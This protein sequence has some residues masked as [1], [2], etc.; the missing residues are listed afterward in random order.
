MSRE[1][2]EHGM[3]RLLETV[4]PGVLCAFDF[5][6]T[7][8]PLVDDPS[9]ARIPP[10]LL[11]RLAALA[12]FA[13][14]AVITGRSVEDISLNLDFFPH[15]LIGNHGIE[16]LS[17]EELHEERYRSNCRHWMQKLRSA[18]IRAHCEPAIWIED[19]VY[20][21]AIH[22]RMVEDPLAAQ[23]RLVD[24]V[25]RTTPDARVISGKCVLNLL[26]ADAPD[27]G[28]ALNELISMIKAPAAIYVGDDV[29]DETVFK[30][31]RDRLLTIRVEEAQQ[32]AAEFH[33]QDISAMDSFL[34][35]L[36]E[37]LKTVISADAAPASPAHRY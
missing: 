36:L 18:M 29:A 6:G 5:D 20:S 21:L 8:A 3:N 10:P 13:P 26:P 4:Q 31:P 9:T 37:R 28:I 27:K 7:I 33:L 23:R 22:Y 1:F 17:G 34:D 2:F 24:L 25:R 19:K 14:V 32:T 12:E 11:R 30:L 35:M 16:G 15:F